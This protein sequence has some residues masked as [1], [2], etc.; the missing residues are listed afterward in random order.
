MTAGG[1]GWTLGARQW[2]GNIAKIDGGTCR[3]CVSVRVLETVGTRHVERGAG[4]EVRH[5]L[6]RA[7]VRTKRLA[8]AIN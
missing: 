7:A 4:A 1:L 6:S 2:S 5:P 8:G 3:V